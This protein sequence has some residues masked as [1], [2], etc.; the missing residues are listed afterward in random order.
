MRERGTAYAVG[1]AAVLALTGGVVASDSL[2]RGAGG[3]SA[4]CRGVHWVAGWV[5]A[6]SDAARPDGSGGA[7][8]K[9]V[10]DA[11]TV[12]MVVH[13]SIG[14]SRVRIRL[15]HR[16]GRAP[17]RV[18][19][20]TIAV[21]R[22]GATVA[23]GSVRSLAFQ[24]RRGVTLEPGEDAVSDPARLRF[25]AGQDLLVSLH[26]PGV[27]ARP[28][29]H[30]LTNQTNYLS[31]RGAGDH[32]SD[33]SGAGFP[34]RVGTD[35]SGGWYFLSGVD[36]LAP[37][38]TG[39]VVAFGD[40]ITD[41]FQPALVDGPSGPQNRNVRYPDFLAT[42]T[43]SRGS[44]ERVSVLNSGI[45]GNRVLSDASPPR[46]YGVAALDRF[47]ADALWLPGVRDVILLQGINDLRT[48]PSLPPKQLTDALWF[49]VRQAQLGGVRVHLG[50]LAPQDGAREGTPRVAEATERRR[51][52]VNR[53]IRT[54]GVADSVVDFDRALRDPARPSRLRPAFDSG[55]H[56]HP[57]SAGY[58]AMA[59]AV[60]LERLNTGCR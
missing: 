19:H 22:Q 6:P 49:L 11:Q 41:G 55:D 25:R 13:P 12:R 33:V 31:R 9:P 16:F 29:E 3:P 15:S 2:N 39:A 17:A 51:Q 5:A 36:V 60:P 54:S 43:R 34:I 56:L 42:R 8:A 52:V 50:T 48:D 7:D 57:N 10:L 38:R 58:R 4:A 28:T 30:S 47:R 27:V 40:S 35:G 21:R 1:L 24:G 14:G 20:A 18:G 46:P 37:R 26:V 45:S 32:A 44:A 53:W 23:P 59:N